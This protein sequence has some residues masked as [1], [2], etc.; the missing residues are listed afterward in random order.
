MLTC[1]L[2]TRKMYAMTDAPAATLGMQLVE[3]KIGR[4]VAE[5][6]RDAYIVREMT[7]ADIAS[8]LGIDTA[9]VSRWM[10]R[11]G[12]PARVIGHRKRRR[13]A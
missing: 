1:I 5:Y 4:P 8:D 11:H 2:Q 7:Q 12:I 13:A 9:T 3:T 10:A 6:L